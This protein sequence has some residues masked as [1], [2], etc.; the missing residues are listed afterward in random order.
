MREHG[1]GFHG[2]PFAY[3]PDGKRLE[4]Q[5]FGRARPTARL[6]V[7]VYKVP[8]GVMSHEVLLGADSCS[9]FHES[10]LD[11]VSEEQTLLRLKTTLPSDIARSP[12]KKQVPGMEAY[13]KSSHHDD[14]SEHRLLSDSRRDMRYYADQ[15]YW[16]PL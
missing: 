10:S 4:V 11:Y 13:I 2:Q 7:N 15:I 6:T 5:M 12:E 3:R 9:V 14:G 8:D 1:S 16:I